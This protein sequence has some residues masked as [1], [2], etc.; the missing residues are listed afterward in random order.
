[1]VNV[2]KIEILSA[3]ILFTAELLLFVKF[4]VWEENFNW[5]NSFALAE[6]KPKIN[7]NILGKRKDNKRQITFY[8]SNRGVC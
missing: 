8:K 5:H 2:N 3:I 7:W 6:I 4:M 1:M